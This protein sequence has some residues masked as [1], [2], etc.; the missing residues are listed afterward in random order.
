MN[1]RAMFYR[2]GSG[3][4]LARIENI[5]IGQG[6]FSI[7]AWELRRAKPLYTE[8]PFS[9]YKR[10]SAQCTLKKSLVNSNKHGSLHRDFFPVIWY[11]IEVNLRLSQQND[12]IS[13][14]QCLFITVQLM[15][16]Q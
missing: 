10:Q 3:L 14:T 8:S 9:R 11:E 1:H 4:P 7:V 2:L 5:P 15:F 13:C 16:F 6:Y 12:G